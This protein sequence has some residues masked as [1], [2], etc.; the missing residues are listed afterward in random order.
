MKSYLII[1]FLL[2][3]FITN[4][5]AQEPLNGTAS[6]V[7]QFGGSYQD[8]A[9]TM[10]V[11]EEGDYIL[12]GSTNSPDGDVSGFHW[13]SEGKTDAW[14]VKVSADGELLWQKCLGGTQQE[15]ILSIT[16]FDGNYIVA[17]YTF[18]SNYDVSDN[19]GEGDLWLLR[20]NDNGD[21]VW[22]ET[23]G[24]TSLE[25]ANSLFI[26]NENNIVVVGYTHS[27]DL[28]V[29]DNY[30][31][32]DVWV[33]KV[34][35]SGELLWEKTFGGTG[36]D[37][38]MEITFTPDNT[39]AII[40]S[41]YSN[42]GLVSGNHGGSDIWVIEIDESGNLLWQNCF[43][44]SEFERAN[45]IEIL[46][47]GSL[48]LAGVSTSSDGDVSHNYGEEDFWLLKLN[49]DKEIVWENNLGGSDGEADPSIVPH[50]DN[51]FFLA[52]KT[53]SDDGDIEN[54]T[55]SSSIWIA[56]IDSIG[57]LIWGDCICYSDC[58][59]ADIIDLGN[60]NYALPGFINHGYW[61]G[62]NDM[63]LYEFCS[64]EEP[65]SILQSSENY[66]FANQLSVQGGFGEYLWSTGENGN[67][68]EVSEEGTYT[69]SS[70]SLAGCTVH[71]QI[72][73]NAPQTPYPIDI[74][75][76]SYD[77]ASQKN[78]I[79]Y[80]PFHEQGSDS[81]LIFKYSNQ[82]SEYEQIGVFEAN[83]AGVFID[84]DSNPDAHYADYTIAMKD[85]C[86][87]VSDMGTTHRTIHLRGQI[88]DNPSNSITLTW[89]AYQGFSIN[90]YEIHR[91]IQGGE[92]E[93]IGEVNA[94][95]LTFTDSN[96]PEGIKYYQ[97]R[98][99]KEN[100]CYSEGGSFQTISSN[101]LQVSMVGLD[102]NEALVA[103]RVF[104]NPFKNTLKI[105][106]RQL[107][108]PVEALITNAF[109]QVVKRFTLQENTVETNIATST[110][111]PGV[112]YLIIRNNRAYKII[113]QPL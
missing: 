32:R 113:K 61:D 71:Q 6:N 3:A 35:S 83:H 62:M 74:C 50:G 81:V 38:G 104:P 17:G 68:I 66:C 28:D 75:M 94:D 63:A 80:E 34:S 42:D 64:F 109:G 15:S 110:L 106:Y 102:E 88:T 26:D 90:Q 70:T 37:T 52:A 21:I 54:A 78:S 59:S 91:K 14:V 40:A 31:D 65:I 97:I 9:N 56:S 25:Q 46:A 57:N 7:Y 87:K 103:T 49:S 39:Y 58:F 18:S 76:V 108:K 79:V 96:I 93:K 23:F 36:E 107:T 43:G 69:V 10:L 111:Q 24:G 29:S 105:Q 67:S 60:G 95:N 77:W 5:F 72:S 16:K 51:G 12:A 84:E 89:N 45:D 98:I 86:G 55:Y 20:L 1:P 8:K 41:T 2:V 4:I 47:D 48:V 19:N 44:G 101:P 92:Y 11:T 53:F 27:N 73:V 82:S 85:T 100:A 112:Y 22:E 33:I 13:G 99:S 30:G